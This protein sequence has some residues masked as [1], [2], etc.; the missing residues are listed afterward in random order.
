M[1]N[2]VA[3]LILSLALIRRTKP[4]F[5]SAELHVLS[6]VLFACFLQPVYVVPY[7]IV[8]FYLSPILIKLSKNSS[9]YSAVFGLLPLLVA[10]GS[11]TFA[12]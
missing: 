8:T 5:W 2:L 10:A 9:Y 6:H 12:W 11:T 1:I 7:L 3:S 4:S